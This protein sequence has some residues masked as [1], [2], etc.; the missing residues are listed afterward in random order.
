MRYNNLIRGLILAATTAIASRIIAVNFPDTLNFRRTST[1]QTVN[2]L[3][4][5]SNSDL[6]QQ[7]TNHYLNRTPAPAL[8]TNL[9]WEQAIKLRDEFV[10]A[11][12]PHLGQV[13]GY[14]AGLTSST[15]QE[16]FGVSH[17]V[18]GI[19]L[20]QMLLENGAVVSAN[21]GA[22]P[23]FE[24]DLM[25]RV[26]DDKINEATTPQEVLAALDVV[27]PLI[28][29]PDLVYSS[30]VKLDG[31]AIIAINVGARLA[32]MGEPIPLAATEEWEERL[33][34]IEVVIL[35]ETGKELAQGESSALLGHPLKAV[36]WLRD[37]LKESGKRLL[38]GDLLSLGTI[39]PLMPVEA[40]KTIRARYIGLDADQVIEVSVKF[41]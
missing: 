21:F 31:A 40:G 41:K 3:A 22:R 20:E 2:Q 39:T 14:K 13:V 27:I 35:D 15:A 10:Q 30:D 28:E 33:G 38:P 17:P 4:P 7:L 23:L 12:I 9:T 25:V 37:D 24:G 19:F 29:L 34:K 18:R 26:A 32:V 11:L 6:T 36:L 5:T 1:Q 8:T 16:R